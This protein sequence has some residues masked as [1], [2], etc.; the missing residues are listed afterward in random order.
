[1][2]CHH[3]HP[4]ERH[5]RPIFAD[6]FVPPLGV[7]T[8]TPPKGIGDPGCLRCGRRPFLVTTTT[9][10]KGIGDTLTF[11]SSRSLAWSPRPP[12]RKALETSSRWVSQTALRSPRPPRR[13]ALETEHSHF[14]DRPIW[15]SPRPPRRKALETRTAG[16]YSFT[17]RSPRPPRRKAL[18]TTE[19]LTE[20]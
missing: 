12:R 13:K 5:W 3:D 18:E 19:Y 14:P 17:L 16:L 20:S 6:D 9:P 15:R 10:P 8:A 2:S 7:T 11:N 1:M 4:A